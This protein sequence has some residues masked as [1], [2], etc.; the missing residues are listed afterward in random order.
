MATFRSPIGSRGVLVIESPEP[1]LSIAIWADLQDPSV[2]IGEV[3]TNTDPAWFLIQIAADNAISQPA[4][5][6]QFV[7]SLES[8]P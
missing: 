8:Q 6:E 5:T 1:V 7:F 4:S 3:L 2:L